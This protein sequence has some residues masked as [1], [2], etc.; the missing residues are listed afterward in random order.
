M[1]V[2]F[3]DNLLDPEQ[4]KK[5]QEAFDQALSATEEE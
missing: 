5:V 2:T 1:P 4:A 3:H